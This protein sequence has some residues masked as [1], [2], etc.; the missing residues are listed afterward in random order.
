MV[1]NMGYH[2]KIKLSKEE[3]NQIMDGWTIKRY[4]PVSNVDIDIG[5][6]DESHKIPTG[7]Y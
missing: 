4:Y 6:L 1:R 5:K 7:E 3:I 2:F